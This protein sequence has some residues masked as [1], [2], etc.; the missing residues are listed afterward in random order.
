MKQ[1]PLLL[2]GLLAFSASAFADMHAIEAALKHPSRPHADTMRDKHRKP[3]DI[4]AF[5][6]VQPGM[7]IIDFLAGKGYYS[8]LFAHLLNNQGTLYSVRGRLAERDFSTYQNT[9]A[10]KDFYLSEIDQPVDRIFTALNYHD[11]VNS[12]KVD[13]R[14]VLQAIHDKLKDDGYFVVIDH[15][16]HPG[17]G[18]S[19]TKSKHRVEGAFVLNEVLGAGF[20]LDSVSTALA[21]PDDNYGLD[22]W[23]ESTKGQTDRFVYRFK[24]K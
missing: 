7:T 23:Q 13:R 22:V 20:K 1:A 16:T 4:L 5:L 19:D 6:D 10:V 9:R 15:N 18:I 21:N 3:A 24:K 8:E 12:D 11:M 2:A 14:K 17:A